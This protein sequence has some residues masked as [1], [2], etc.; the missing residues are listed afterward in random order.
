MFGPFGFGDSVRPQPRRDLKEPTIT[1]PKC[2]RRTKLIRRNSAGRKI[3]PFCL[4][5][6]PEKADE[7]KTENPA[8]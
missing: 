7:K 2:G 6:L 5:V 1:C 3:C 4:A 8:P